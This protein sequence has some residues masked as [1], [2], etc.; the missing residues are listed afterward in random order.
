MI[1][2]NQVRENTPKKKEKGKED[3]RRTWWK[4]KHVR[5]SKPMLNRKVHISSK[6]PRPNTMTYPHLSFYL[7]SPIP[8]RTPPRTAEI[9][10]DREGHSG[11]PA[12][13][14]DLSLPKAT[15]AK[16]ITGMHVLA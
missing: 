13:D 10:S 5:T 14:E 9:M 11:A 12:S 15:V 16:M 3:V 8:H 7:R 6:R 4:G 1:S 2:E